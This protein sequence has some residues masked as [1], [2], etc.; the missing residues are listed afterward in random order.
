MKKYADYRK[1]SINGRINFKTRNLYSFDNP[2]NKNYKDFNL[3][4]W[5]L[6]NKVIP[7]FYGIKDFNNF[8]NL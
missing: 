6:K 3:V 7:M 1:L 8:I 2:F 5:V 4:N